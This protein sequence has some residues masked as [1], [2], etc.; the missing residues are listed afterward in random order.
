[1]RAALI[2]LAVAAAF[3]SCGSDDERAPEPSADG[4][5][6]TY[7]RSGGIAFTVQALEVN[8]DG[9]ATLTLQEGTKPR[10]KGVELANAELASLTEAVEAV[11]PSEID[12]PT[13]G[14]CADCYTYGLTFADGTELEFT[15]YPEPP[16]ELDPLLDQLS[17]IVEANSP[18][19][20]TVR[21]RPLRRGSAPPRAPARARRR[22]GLPEPG[23][24]TR[25]RRAGRARR[26]GGR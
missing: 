12:L 5:L 1:M 7:D 19:N 9:T 23:L 24:G 4:P 22:A 8:A 2:A 11:N 3:A 14:V 13:V 16:T 17:G 18:A 20:P 25:A 15:E 26:R 10:S 6:I 21:S